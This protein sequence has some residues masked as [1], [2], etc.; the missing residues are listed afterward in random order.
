MKIII[1]GNDR[2]VPIKLLFPTGLVLNRLTVTFIPKALKDN[3]GITITR[4]QALRL[5]KELRRCKKR[6][7]GWKIVE[8]KSADGECVEITL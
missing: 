3:C 6:F 2:H 8:V 5:I 7:P 1:N 4:K